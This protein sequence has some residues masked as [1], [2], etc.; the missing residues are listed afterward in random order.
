MLANTVIAEEAD[1]SYLRSTCYIVLLASGRVVRAQL[2]DEGRKA[3]RAASLDVQVNTKRNVSGYPG[4][5]GRTAVPIEYGVTERTSRARAAKKEVPDEVSERL[6]L[7]IGREAC[8]ARSTAE[9]D[10]YDFA[11]RSFGVSIGQARQIMLM[12]PC[13]GTSGCP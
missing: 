6:S 9:A 13:S 1:D 8:G 3:G 11:L 7:R 12:S 5:C 2:R 10:R 4:Q